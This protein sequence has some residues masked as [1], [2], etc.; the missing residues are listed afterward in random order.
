LLRDAAPDVSKIVLAFDHGLARIGIATGNEQTRTATPLTTLAARAGVPNWNELDR[1]VTDWCPTTLVVGLP[2]A[3]G[4]TRTDVASFAQALRA[5]YKLPL[6]AVDETLTSRAAE[7]SLREHR[8]RGGHRTKKAAIDGH[9]ACLIA[10]QWM[11]DVR[12]DQISAAGRLRHLITLEGL[13]QAQ[14]EQI[15]RRARHY[16]PRVTQAP[17]RDEALK[18]TTVANLFYEASTRTRASFELAARRLSADVLSLDINTSS[19]AKGESILDTIYTLQAMHIDIFVVRDAGTG[20]PAKIADA[21]APH[22]CVLNAGESDVSHPTQGL[23]DLLTIQLHK[24]DVADLSIAIVGDVRHS[25][26][27]R[28]LSQVLQLYG[29][30]DLRLIGPG[31]FMPESSEFIGASRHE[32]V[33]EGLRDADVVM[34]L[35]IQRERLRR[36]NET[37]DAAEY[38]GRFGL[39]RARMRLAKPDAIVMHPGPMNR[40]IEIADEVADS[41][42]SVVREQVANGVAVRMGV[43][44]MVAE[45]VRA[46][47]GG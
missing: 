47:R 35:R 30:K 22:V 31:E 42:Q 15:L 23:L 8:R 40:G 14:I 4:S 16:L 32:S 21:V 17:P 11:S 19:R 20:V 33:D 1:I 38:F 43:L 36:A 46:T 13:T 34:T 10:E 7:S 27:A 41:P 2:P 24:G 18:G 6:Y 39:T 45:H 29:V 28:S 9:A 37:P 12:V 5:R 3:H 44:A 26:V 25:R